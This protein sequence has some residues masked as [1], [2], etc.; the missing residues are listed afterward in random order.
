MADTRVGALCAVLCGLLTGAGFGTVRAQGLPLW[1]LGAGAA[2]LRV[3]DYRGSEEVRNYVLPIPWVVYRGEILRADREGLRARLF[4]SER[5]D[6]NLSV[7]GSVPV[8]S[9][10]NRAREGMPDL[11]PLFEVGPVANVHLWRTDDRR[12]A[13]DLR[14]PARAAFTFKGGVEHVGYVFAPQLNLDLRW[15][16]ATAPDR[17]NIGLLIEAPFS[18]RRMNGYFYSVSAAEATPTRP[19][20]SARAG[21]GGWQTLAA[22]SHRTDRWWIGGFIKYDNLTGSVFADSPLVTQRRQLSGGIAVSYVFARS[23]TLV[24]PRD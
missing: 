9:N 6:L 2:A 10:R 19:P 22:L 16:S 3:P 24:P 1:E 21:Y 14:L 5:V 13:L 4:D 15:P 7:N 23:S 11:R 8:D 20:Y 17:W 12:A 18:D